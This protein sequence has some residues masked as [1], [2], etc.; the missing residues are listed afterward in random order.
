[1]NKLPIA[2]RSIRARMQ[3]V[4][5]TSFFYTSFFLF[6]CLMVSVARAAPQP[7]AD[8]VWEDGTRYV[9]GL[10]SGKKNGKGKIV[11][12][13]GTRFRGTFKNDLREGTGKLILPDESSYVAMFKNDVVVPGSARQESP[14]AFI[15][16]SAKFSRDM[17]ERFKSQLRGHVKSWIE[18][19]AS[20]NLPRYFSHYSTDFRPIDGSY[21][22]TWKRIRRS[23]ISEPE[24][25][26][27]SVDDFH[28]KI[29]EAQNATIAFDQRYT[30]N[31][32]S[33]VVRKQ[34][35]LRFEEDGWR[36]LRELVID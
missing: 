34:L 15:P 22:S 19:W 5:T 14:S 33:D 18:A 13:D 29:L 28:F 3:R 36:I 25:I 26:K 21:I 4:M 6:W 1:M 32:Y 2:R 11:W 9:G 16:V 23:R 12:V 24:S 20:Q 31:L 30:S 10:M 8:K 27:I 7:E 35:E 17:N